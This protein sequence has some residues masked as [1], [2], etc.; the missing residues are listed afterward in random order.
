MGLTGNFSTFTYSDHPTDTEEQQ[1]MYP[2]NLPSDDPNYENRGQTVTVSVPVQ[3]ETET[4]NENKYININSANVFV[5]NIYK[6]GVEQDVR[7]INFCY[8]SYGSK[9]DR[10]ADINDFET[11][12]HTQIF[13]LPSGDRTE[14][15][16]CYDLLKSERGFSSM[17]DD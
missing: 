3:V 8:R 11:E 2:P 1:I 12:V 7:M 15:Q 9:A 5:A 13:E 4:V 16:K 17:I 6:D 14:V 10:A